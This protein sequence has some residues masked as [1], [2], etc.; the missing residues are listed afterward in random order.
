MKNKKEENNFENARDKT[1]E[2]SLLRW[3][4]FVRDNPT[5]W[6]EQLKPFLDSQIISARKFREKLSET[7]EG[8]KTIKALIAMKC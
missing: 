4:E 2:E 1:H 8:R 7:E 6:K 5:K 3:A